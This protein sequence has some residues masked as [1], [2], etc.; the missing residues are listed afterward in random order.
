[1]Q[2]EQGR[3]H[4]GVGV[5]VWGVVVGDLGGGGGLEVGDVGKIAKLRIAGVVA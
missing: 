1:M 3:V 5:G 4:V 2:L